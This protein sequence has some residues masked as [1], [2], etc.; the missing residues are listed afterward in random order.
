MFVRSERFTVLPDGGGGNGFCT[1]CGGHCH[2]LGGC[3]NVREYRGSV[4]CE[5]IFRVG[6]CVPGPEIA[7]TR[8]AWNSDRSTWGFSR[9][10]ERVG[11]NVRE[12]GRN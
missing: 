8:A 4:H 2:L 3:S 9:G 1:E 6:R 7:R 10:N 12:L 11:T 5:H